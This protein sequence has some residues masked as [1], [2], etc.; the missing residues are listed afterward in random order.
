[1]YQSRITS[2]KNDGSVH[3]QT[4]RMMRRSVVIR[5]V[6]LRIGQQIVRCQIHFKHYGV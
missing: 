3:V 1:M 2:G 6:S 4:T 5:V